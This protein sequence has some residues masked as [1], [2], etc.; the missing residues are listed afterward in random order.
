MSSSN[1]PSTDVK[2]VVKQSYD[3]IASSYTAWARARPSTRLRYL[4]ELL[5]TLPHDSK[6]LEL[7]CGAGVPVTKAL[8]DNENVASVVANDI[9]DAQVKLAQEN[10]ERWN[11]K[12]KFITG[13]MMALD[14]DDQAFDGI[15]AFYA[16]FHL[17]RDEQPKMIKKVHAW[18]KPGAILVCNFG[19]SDTNSGGETET[20]NKR[21]EKAVCW[22]HFQ[23]DMFWSGHGVEGT[24]KMLTDAGFELVTADVRNTNEDLD[25]GDDSDPDKDTEFLF[26]VA[27]KAA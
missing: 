11:G 22:T 1:M 13:D 25:P 27:R 18:L 3:K 2:Q 7:G 16:I 23:T 8:C 24:K 4:N 19:V 20:T 5:K 26:I 12:V 14:F 21:D 17:P 9:S 10:P 6:I 15:V